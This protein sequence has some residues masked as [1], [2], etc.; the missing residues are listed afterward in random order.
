M[1]FASVLIV[2]F[3]LNCFGMD[4]ILISALNEVLGTH[5]SNNVFWLIAFV[6]AIVVGIIELVIN[7]IKRKGSKA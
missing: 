1:S 5:Y 4:A 7:K 2:A 3:I 6:L